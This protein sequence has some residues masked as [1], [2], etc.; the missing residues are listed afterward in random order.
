MTPDD[1]I[2]FL[3]LVIPLVFVVIGFK[4]RTNYKIEQL[5]QD[6]KTEKQESTISGGLG[7]MI[8]EAPTQLKQI[9]SEIAIFP[10][11][12]TLAPSGSFLPRLTN[13]IF[14]T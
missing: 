6:G 11:C 9:E 13:N 3:W 7:K 10:F 8:K 4:I 5:K 2:P 12:G 1:F 14:L